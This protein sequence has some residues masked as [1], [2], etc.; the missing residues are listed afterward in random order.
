ME[1]VGVAGH[2]GGLELSVKKGAAPV[3]CL[4][5]AEMEREREREVKFGFEW[6]HS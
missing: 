4:Q 5:S 6:H 1:R 3:E 2:D